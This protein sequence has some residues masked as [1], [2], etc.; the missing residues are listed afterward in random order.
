MGQEPCTTVMVS[1]FLHQM[2][3]AARL[4][5]SLPG[6]QKYCFWKALRKLEFT[7]ENSYL[8]GTGLSVL[9]SGSNQG[10]ITSCSFF[11]VGKINIV[12]SFS[13]IPF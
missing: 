5:A 6:F 13:K 11:V 10:L 2:E 8:P 9:P 3:E 12:L 4:S 1:L 7:E